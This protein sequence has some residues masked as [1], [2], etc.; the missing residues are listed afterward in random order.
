MVVSV[1]EMLEQEGIHMSNDRVRIGIIGGGGIAQA[2]AAQYLKLPDVHVTAVADIV[3]GRAQAFIER[4]GL[5]GTRAFTDYHDLLAL[6]I[7]GVDICTFNRAHCQ[8]AIDALVAH[9]HTMVVKPMSVTL[10]EAVAMVHTSRKTGAMLMINFISRWEP[11]TLAARRVVASGE[12][13][14]IYYVESGGGR[15]YGIP[16]G[17]F[18]S[19]AT[20]GGGAVLDIGC[21]A[22]DTVMYALGNPRPLTVSATTSAHLG[23]SPD[24]SPPNRTNT[25]RLTLAPSTWKTLG[26]L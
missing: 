4:M 11:H 7:D 10:E 20:A 15:R 8:P 1:T 13:G 14:Q 22:I 16:G 21:Y 19:K 18:I 3:P 26:S 25:G 6:D 12:L 2:H 9:K 24:Y 23:S 5:V 17:T